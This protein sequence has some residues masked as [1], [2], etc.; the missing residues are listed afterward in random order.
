MNANYE[1]YQGKGRAHFL[2]SKLKITS[3]CH[4]FEYLNLIKNISTQ[5]T[6][7]Q[8]LK[9][10]HEIFAGTLKTRQKIIF[11]A[12]GTAGRVAEINPDL[13]KFVPEAQKKSVPTPEMS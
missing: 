11:N 8:G 1:L 2:T 6:S 5:K 13:R 9:K 4:Y 3:S 12:L 7:L 10:V